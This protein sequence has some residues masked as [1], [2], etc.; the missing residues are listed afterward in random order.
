[1]NKKSKPDGGEKMKDKNY[2]IGVTDSFQPRIQ[3]A[4]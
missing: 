2:Q 1:M 4:F 3:F